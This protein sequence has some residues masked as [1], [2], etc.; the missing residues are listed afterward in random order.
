MVQLYRIFR[1][2]NSTFEDPID[3]SEIESLEELINR[4]LYNPVLIDSV[5]AGIKEY[6]D[7]IIPINN[8]VYFYWIQAV[9]ISGT[10]KIAPLGIKTHV[11][12]KP[13]EFTVANPFPNPFNAATRL[14]YSLSE[15]NDVTISVYTITG[16]KVITLIDRRLNAGTHSIT[17]K[18]LTE[19]G[20]QAGTGVYIFRLYAGKKC[21]NR[22][23]VLLR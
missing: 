10:S 18:G 3:I 6:T 7:H 23:I 16:Q 9:G 4:E 1:S 11:E 22:R 15:P 20:Q 21:E 17:W 12:A 2:R 14:V 5:D 19:N 8:V 13:S